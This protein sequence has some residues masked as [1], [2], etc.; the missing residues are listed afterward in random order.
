MC[1]LRYNRKEVSGE[2]IGIGD[3]ASLKE[4]VL[5]NIYAANIGRN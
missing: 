4:G 5:Y 2:R 3:R 1:Y